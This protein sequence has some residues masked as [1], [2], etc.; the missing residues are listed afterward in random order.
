MTVA[1]DL[2][3]NHDRMLIVDRHVL[4]LLALDFL[5]IDV[6]LSRSSGVATGAKDLAAEEFRNSITMRG[7]G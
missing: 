1:D 3:R 4:Y 6:D 7:G 2:V 5:H